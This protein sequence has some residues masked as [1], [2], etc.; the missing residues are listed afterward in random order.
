MIWVEIVLALTVLALA[1]A[2]LLKKGSSNESKGLETMREEYSRQM[3]KLQAMHQTEMATRERLFAEQIRA[4]KE[5]REREIAAITEN[6]ETRFKAFSSAMMQQ[7]ANNL[8]KSNR[9]QLDLLL[10][11]L[12]NRI[13]EFR[14]AV[15][16]SALEDKASRKSFRDKIEE[17]VNLN[18]RLGDEADKLSNA[19]RGQHKV[20]GDW[21]EKI[22]T[23]LLEQGGLSRGIHFF[24]QATTDEDGNPLRNEEGRGL[25][26]DVV[27][28][29]PDNRKLIIDSKVTMPSW[30]DLCNAG[31]ESEK[32]DATSRLVRSVRKHIDELAS[33]RYQ[34]YIGT[35]PDLV[36][37]FVPVEGAFLEALHA[38]RDLWNYAWERN[39]ALTAPTQLFAVMHIVTNIWKAHSRDNNA[40]KIAKKAGQLQ[41]KILLFM[42]SFD[43]LGNSL[44]GALDLY[45]TSMTRLCTGAGNI[46]KTTKDLESLGVKGKTKGKKQRSI[47]KGFLEAS[48]IE[49]PDLSDETGSLEIETDTEAE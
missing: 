15:E 3:E 7:T 49:E 6:V 26:P 1:F 24:E 41:E 17:L 10:I 35:T 46:V 22:L 43:N 19:L 30:I 4:E 18:N 31:D 23:T 33:K 27:V 13:E 16:E 29:L 25:R 32:K 47:P 44:K 5:A 40:L 37:M 36:V 9:E 34:D 45:Q 8:G 14:K 42:E 11:P 2:L 48:D 38:D 39:V 21:G 12:K 20:M 28:N